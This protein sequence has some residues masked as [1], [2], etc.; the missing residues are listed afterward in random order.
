MR[1]TSPS[2]LAAL[3]VLSGTAGW[4]G[5][6]LADG[7]GGRALQ[8]PPSAP[9]AMAIFAVA[10]LIWT[11]LARPRLLR[12]PGTRPLAPLVAARSAA[13]ALAASRTGA[14]VLGL[15]GGAAV[16]LMPRWNTGQGRESVLASGLSAVGALLVMV[17]GLW[18]EKLCRV[19]DG[20][21][22]NGASGTTG[23]VVDGNPEPAARNARPA[24]RAVRKPI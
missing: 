23:R 16:G 12:K 20:D 11:L 7:L 22:H 8:I 19:R 6:R 15:Y 4:A 18:L 2:L 3:T 5:A 10:L 13:L 14:L 21:D 1:P 9:L 17:I 24:G